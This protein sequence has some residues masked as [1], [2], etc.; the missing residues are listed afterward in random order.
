MVEENISKEVRLENM[1][2]TNKYLRWKTGQNELISNNCKT[3]CATLNYI[4][5]F[6]MSASTVN[7]CIWIFAFA[8]L[9][10]TPIGV[11]Q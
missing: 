7:R 4:E 2:E 10:G 9:L 8:S 6:F 1:D 11:L 5:Q 3:V